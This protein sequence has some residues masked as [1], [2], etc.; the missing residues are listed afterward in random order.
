MTFFFGLP[1]PA[2]AEFVGWLAPIIDH[3]SCTGRPGPLFDDDDPQDWWDAAQH[4]MAAETAE[5]SKEE[6]QEHRENI[7]PQILR[8]VLPLG[9]HLTGLLWQD[10]RAL[11]R[12]AVDW[13]VPQSLQG[14]VASR[15]GA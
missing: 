13:H 2:V 9:E 14:P 8:H 11:S 7:P 10:A 3:P 12:R 1:P 6:T 5:A 15:R 4:F